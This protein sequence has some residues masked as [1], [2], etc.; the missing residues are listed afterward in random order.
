[1]HRSVLQTK[2][3]KSTLP[4]ADRSTT[5]VTQPISYSVE[6]A[7]RKAILGEPAYVIIPPITVHFIN[8]DETTGITESARN[9]TRVSLAV[10]GERRAPFSPVLPRSVAFSHRVAGVC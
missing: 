8:Y 9:N 5:F 2:R 3:G 7:L 1:M 10:F 6:C 4:S